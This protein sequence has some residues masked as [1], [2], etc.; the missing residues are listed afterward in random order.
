M[1]VEIRLN[2]IIKRDKEGVVVEGGA[3]ECQIELRAGDY[4]LVS[5]WHWKTRAGAEKWAELFVS[6]LR[7]VDMT[8][9][10]VRIVE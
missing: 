1:S 5:P 3:R 7:E 2:R 9:L 10:K 4:V 6:K 8:D